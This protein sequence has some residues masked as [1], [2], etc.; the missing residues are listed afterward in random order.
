MFRFIYLQIFV[1]I[2]H[3]QERFVAGLYSGHLLIP[4]HNQSA[5]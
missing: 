5:H 4:L 1:H 2:L 3:K